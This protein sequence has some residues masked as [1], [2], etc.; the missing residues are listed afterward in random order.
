MS[1][2]PRNIQR[3]QLRLF[4]LALGWVLPGCATSVDGTVRYQVRGDSISE[5]LT[6]TPGDATRGRLIVVSRDG[7]CL[8][9]HSIPET[10]ERS[11]GNVA[12]PLSRV[13]N[14]LSEGQ[15]RLRVVDPTR[16]SRDVVMPAY[17]RVH[18][19]HGVAEPYRGKPILTAQQVEDVVAYLVTLR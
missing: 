15:L 12:P 10:G 8:L 14:R 1:G 2:P 3:S 13:A 18:A 9:C 7:N 19:P 16:V 17:Y 4:F 6:P 5:P 11:M